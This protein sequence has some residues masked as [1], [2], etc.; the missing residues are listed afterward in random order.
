MLMTIGGGI[1]SVHSMKEDVSSELSS[2][3]KQ[4]VVQMSESSLSPVSYTSRTAPLAF[5]SRH[6]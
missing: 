3:V 1:C 5:D 2:T 4:L 6:L